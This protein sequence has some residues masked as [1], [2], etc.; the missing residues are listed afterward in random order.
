MKG[1]DTAI[2]VARA[3]GAKLILV[4]CVQNKPDDRAFFEEMKR[5][6]DLVVDVSR[7]PVGGAYYDEVMKPILSSDRQIIYIGEVD[8]EAKKHW[9]IVP[10]Y[11]PSRAGASSRLPDRDQSSRSLAAARDSRVRSRAA[12]SRTARV[13]L[14]RLY[15]Y[16]AGSSEMDGVMS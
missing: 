12:R 13:P 11:L 7:Y 8:T 3:S 9:L 16:G 6:V 5:S 14:I 1:Q 15:N 2:E 4:G 10:S